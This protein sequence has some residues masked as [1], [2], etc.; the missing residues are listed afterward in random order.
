MQDA[1]KDV[2]LNVYGCST[3]EFKTL[4]STPG[5]G[6]PPPAWNFLVIL[7]FDHGCHPYHP[8]TLFTIP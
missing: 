2:R 7:K 1:A 5:P 6:R 4:V 8:Y 3:C